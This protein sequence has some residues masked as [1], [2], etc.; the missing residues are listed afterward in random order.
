MR[1]IEIV[2]A[3][4]RDRAE[5]LRWAVHRWSQAHP[6]RTDRLVR[7]LTPAE[8]VEYA[9]SAEYRS[10]YD[11]A[12]ENVAVAAWLTNRGQTDRLPPE[13]RDGAR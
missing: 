5:D 11:L 1:L 9:G 4:W 10:A 3:A 6:P 12:T 8:V 2:K 7:L 13:F